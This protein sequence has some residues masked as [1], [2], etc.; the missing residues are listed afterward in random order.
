M[1]YKF[2]R[3]ESTTKALRRLCSERVEDALSQIKELRSAAMA[4]GAR[5]Y[6]EKAS[7]FRRRLG[8][9]WNIWC[10]RTAKV[11]GKK[12]KVGKLAK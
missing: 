8:H 5:F 3:K 1:A 9:Y 6:S 11:A 7:A 2:K 12:R 10:R 4:L